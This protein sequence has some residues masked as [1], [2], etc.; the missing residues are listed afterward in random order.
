[1]L[2][3]SYFWLLGCMGLV[4]F[5]HFPFFLTRSPL[6]RT[7]FKPSQIFHAY[8]QRKPNFLCTREWLTI[9]W[10]NKPKDDFHRLADILS[11]GPQLLFEADNLS[12]TNTP[13]HQTLPALLTL[14]SKLLD[15]DQELLS[16]HAELKLNN[17][18]KGPLY[19][20]EKDD[21]TLAFPSPRL[22]SL[23]TLYWSIQTLLYS[24]LSALHA[25]MLQTNTLHHVSH[26]SSD[27]RT[28]R[29]HALAPASKSHWL[30]SVRKI[31]ASFEYCMRESVGSAT[32]PAGMGVALEI[33]I[34]VL[35][36]RR[37]GEET[38]MEAEGNID[39]EVGGIGGGGG[40]QA[41]LEQ[42][43]AAREEMG[44]RWVAIMLA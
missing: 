42:A 6:T 38:G 30:E 31:L 14:L 20:Q 18:E 19:W 37:G 12:K 16:F 26:D 9:P 43:L 10:Q 11:R 4:L 33:V 39:F 21:G 17:E 44:R 7:Y 1:V 34:D 29:F 2:G 25:T 28:I 41:E 36:Q 5:D 23:L 15:I 8:D 35:R 40:F 3:T 22:A 32:P 27:P 13:L 24:S